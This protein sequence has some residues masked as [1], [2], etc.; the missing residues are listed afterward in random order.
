MKAGRL[1]GETGIYAHGTG[2]NRGFRRLP[3]IM[4][5]GPSAISAVK[6]GL[7]PLA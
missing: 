3:Q 2:F 4:K 7:P 5:S 1:N 6:N